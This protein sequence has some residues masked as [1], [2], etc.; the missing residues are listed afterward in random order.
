MK[1]YTVVV[2]DLRMCMKEDN[3]SAINIKEDNSSPINIKEDNS[4]GDHYL[5]K[6]RVA[7]VI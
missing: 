2:Y 6:M 4:Q 3:S 5:C 1:L 7:F